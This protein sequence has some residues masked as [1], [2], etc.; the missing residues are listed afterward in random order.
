M[1]QTMNRIV[2]SAATCAMILAPC[3]A[4]RADRGGV[5][6]AQGRYAVV[7]PLSLA[8][9][10]PSMTPG[11]LNPAVTQHNLGETICRRGGYTRSVRPST[12][13]TSPLKRRQIRD[14]GYTDR[15]MG[16]YEEDHLIPLEI[17]GAPADPRNLWPQPHHVVGGWGSYAKDRLENR[18]HWLVCHRRLGLTDAQHA[19]A[20]DWISA[21]QH[22]VGGQPSNKRRHRY[23]G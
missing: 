11:A 2:L 20:S 12:S 15:R 1:N 3:W 7:F 21:Y 4:A 10:D 17:G 6:G 16:D 22:Y 13:Y 9:P 23:G 19:I 8:R 5:Q 18:L 14:Y